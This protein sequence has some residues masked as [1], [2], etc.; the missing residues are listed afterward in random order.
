MSLAGKTVGSIRPKT[1]GPE[2]RRKLLNYQ[3]TQLPNYKITSL[4]LSLRS[5]PFAGDDLVFHI[6]MLFVFHD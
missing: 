3:I 5:V 1:M 6:V 4:N 2:R